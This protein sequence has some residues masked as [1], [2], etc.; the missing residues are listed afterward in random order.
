MKNIRLTI[1]SC[2]FNANYSIFFRTLETQQLK[3]WRN[4]M[5]IPVERAIGGFHLD[6]RSFLTILMQQLQVQVIP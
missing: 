2:E 6:T 1:P 4:S 3:V 5:G